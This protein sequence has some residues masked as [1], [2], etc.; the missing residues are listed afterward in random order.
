LQRLDIPAAATLFIDD[1]ARN[2]RVAEALGIPSI[3]FPGVEELW[4][5]LADRG[6][7]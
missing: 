5:L 6:I 3:V 4:T 2:T 7:L 1:Q